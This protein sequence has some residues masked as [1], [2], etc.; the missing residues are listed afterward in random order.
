M[1]LSSKDRRNELK[2][3]PGSPWYRMPTTAICEGIA[4]GS[5]AALENECAFHDPA[6]TQEYTYSGG[7]TICLVPVSVFGMS[8]SPGSS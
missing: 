5:I 1:F 8:Q 6:P 2:L 4:N 7:Q 3:E